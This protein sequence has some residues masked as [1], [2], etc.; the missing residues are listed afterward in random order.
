MP[1]SVTLNEESTL[2]ELVNRIREEGKHLGSSILKVDGFINHQLE[3]TLTLAMGHAFA[4]AFRAAG[5]EPITKVITAEVSGIAPAFATAAALNVPVIYARKK[6][7]IT[8]SDE[9]YRATAPSRTKGGV[10]EL[11]VSPE[12]LQP[13]D[14]VLLIDDFLASGKTIAALAGLITESGA[15]LL[16]IGCVIEKAFEQGRSELEHLGVPIVT[17]AVVEAMEGDEITVRAGL[18]GK[19]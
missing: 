4:E 6:H 10:T 17:L 5:A 7:P 14:R 2:Q 3:P 12:Y 19:D 11:I 18:R 16:G 8:M 15:T 13:N 1:L 9:V